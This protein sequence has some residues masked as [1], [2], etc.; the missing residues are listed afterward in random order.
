MPS[1][2]RAKLRF[3]SIKEQDSPSLCLELFFNNEEIPLSS[4]SFLLYLYNHEDKLGEALLNFCYKLAKLL[5]PIRQQ[6]KA[7]YALCEH[8]HV[9]WFFKQIIS[10][11]L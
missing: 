5:R 11:F 7:Y 2:L 9:I 3:I 10:Y 4:S 1:P 8:K 6:N